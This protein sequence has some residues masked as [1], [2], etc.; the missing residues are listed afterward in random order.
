MTPVDAP[1]A[2]PPREWEARTFALIAAIAAA[3]L[4]GILLLVTDL[5]LRSYLVAEGADGLSPLVAWMVEHWEA[6]S[7]LFLLLGFGYLAGF[8]WWR[9]STRAMLRSAGDETGKSVVHWT[10]AA[11][12]LA[13]TGSF[14]LALAGESTD[15]PVELL[16]WDAVRMGLRLVGLA[17]LLTAVWQIRDQ[18]RTQVAGSGIILRP[19]RRRLEPLNL[20]ASAPALAAVARADLPSADDDFWL[21]VAALGDGVA[22]LETTDAVARRWLLVDGDLDAVRSALPAGAVVTV[23]PQPPAATETEGFTPPPAEEYYGLLED[24]G[25]LW[26]QTVRPNRVEAFLAR[27]RRAR[28]WALYPTESPDALVAEVR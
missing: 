16:Q 26:Y 27:A 7:V 20:A 9:S 3:T 10:V 17:F 13:L 14:T 4:L 2:R 6:I 8:Y 25:A 18:V 5:A 11:F 24:D 19:A 12:Y 1:T 15:D 22:V 28:R 21:G 23:F